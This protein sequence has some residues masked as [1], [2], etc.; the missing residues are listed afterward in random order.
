[1]DMVEQRGR[2]VM[3]KVEQKLLTDSYDN[4]L[5]ASALRHYAKFN[6]PLVLPLFPALMSLSYEVV[7]GNK[8]ISEIES[9]ATAMVFI[10]L[11]ADVHDDIIDQSD[12]KYNKKTIYGKFGSEIALLAGDALLIQGHAL[13]HQACEAFSLKQRQ[14]LSVLIPKALFELSAAE[15]LER[16]LSKKSVIAPEEYFEIMRLKGV[17]AELQ[18]RIG[19]IIGQADNETLEAIAS[20]GRIIGMLGTLQDEFSDVSNVSELKHR[21]AFE[22]PPL[23]MVYAIQDE[24]VKSVLNELV[25]QLE[26][27]AVAKKFVKLVLDSDGVCKLRHK[28]CEQVNQE[29]DDWMCSR[30]NRVGS[31]AT[32]LLKAFSF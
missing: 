23:P 15:V 7:K 17:F 14:A 9:V 1:M 5:I 25:E 8:E 16:Q 10:A 22:C 21:I 12:V 32:L 30:K 29:L 20:Y 2:V 11:S 26:S 24:K 28:I 6:L 3:D 19:G 13:L 4:G 27:R 18:C 31:D